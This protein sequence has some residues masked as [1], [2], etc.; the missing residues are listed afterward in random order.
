MNPLSLPEKEVAP[1]IMPDY[2]ETE[3]KKNKKNFLKSP[4]NS[5][6]RFKKKKEAPKKKE[7][8]L[9]RTPDLLPFIKQEK[10]YIVLKN[11]LMDILQIST[12]DL[13]SLNEDELQA[14]M[15]AKSGLFKSYYPGIKEVSLNFPTN[16][17]KQQHYWNK[18]KMKTTD[19]AR[20]R[21][22]ERKIF[23]LEYLAKERTNREFFLFIFA[24][25]EKQLF[26]RREQLIKAG[27][28]SFPLQ[29]LTPEKKIDTLFIL[30]NQNTKL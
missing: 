5:L 19:P 26:E 6:K 10:D 13:Y 25:N 16:T 12:R 24:D 18:K 21:F 8:V 22:I 20:L 14:M 2:Q 30:N 1:I 27:Y 11:G 15:Y 7:K 3:P 28:R 17:S 9:A 23:E 4:K 29:T